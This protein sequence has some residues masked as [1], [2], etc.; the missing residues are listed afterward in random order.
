[1]VIPAVTVVGVVVVSES[2]PVLASVSTG[3]GSSG[4]PVSR[5]EPQRAAMMV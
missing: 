3:V 2:L 1:M 5:T 4:Q